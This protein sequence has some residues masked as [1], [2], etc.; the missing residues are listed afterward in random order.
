MTEYYFPAMRGKNT[1]KSVC[2]H[3]LLYVPCVD[4]CAVPSKPVKS[5]AIQSSRG[6]LTKAK[7]C[8]TIMASS[9]SLSLS[10]KIFMTFSGTSIDVLFMH[11]LS[12]ASTLSYN[13][14]MSL[15]SKGC[16]IADSFN[17]AAMLTR[18]CNSFTSSVEGTKKEKEVV[19]KR[20]GNV[21][22]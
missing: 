3:L 8:L 5:C 15:D 18:A 10:L 11:S 13:S 22:R 6:P 9:P 21:E 14:F 20:C 17:A 19:R 2:M 16:L 7:A 1:F 4:I 12:E